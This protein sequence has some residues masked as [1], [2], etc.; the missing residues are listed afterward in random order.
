VQGRFAAGS[1]IPERWSLTGSTA[2]PVSMNATS[3][4]VAGMHRCQVF[5]VASEVNGF[6]EVTSLLTSAESAIC[7]KIVVKEYGKHG[8]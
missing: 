8:M 2:C 7:Q 5:H 4:S 3:E 6:F 1:R